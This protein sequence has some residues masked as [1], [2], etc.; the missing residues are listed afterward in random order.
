MSKIWG[1]YREYLWKLTLLNLDSSAPSS[2]PWLSVSSPPVHDDPR[3][4]L[5]TVTVSAQRYRAMRCRRPAPPGKQTD[6]PYAAPTSCDSPVMEEEEHG[7]YGE[8]HLPN[9]GSKI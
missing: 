7:N 1:V 3:S 2:L 4:S 9:A 8:G 5:D 6:G